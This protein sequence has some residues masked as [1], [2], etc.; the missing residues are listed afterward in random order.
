MARGRTAAWR[1]GGGLR[2]RAG[3]CAQAG[4][5]QGLQAAWRRMVQIAVAAGPAVLQAGCEARL[6][7]PLAPLALAD[8]GAPSRPASA[9]SLLTLQGAGA[10]DAAVHCASVSAAR[11]TIQTSSSANGTTG[12]S[13]GGGGDSSNGSAPGPSRGGIERASSGKNPLNG[14]GRRLRSA[15]SEL[16]A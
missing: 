4:V 13:N 7:Y 10:Y 1:G 9:G 16:F 15:F 12:G 14:L 3:G 8:A 2:G 11:R 6:P 5:R